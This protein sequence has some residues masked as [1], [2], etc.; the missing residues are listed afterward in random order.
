MFWDSSALVP[1]LVP[2]ARSRTLTD[3]VKDDRQLALWWGT[4]VECHSALQRRRRL[5]ERVEREIGR[6]IS[7]LTDLAEDADTVAPSEEIRRKA[8]GLLS[9]HDLTAADALQLSAAIAWSE[10]RGT[11]E[12]FVCVDQR[13]GA[14]ARLEG[15]VV[16]P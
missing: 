13:L 16:R 15:F 3:L 6:A 12:F 4:I 7:R 10:G 14:A 2:E 9:V 8:V 11:G 5:G 1:V